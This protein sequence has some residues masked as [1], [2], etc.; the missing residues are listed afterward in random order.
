MILPGKYSKVL[1]L[2]KSFA[3]LEPPPRREL[4][5]TVELKVERLAP[6]TFRITFGMHGAGVGDGGVWLAVFTAK[7]AVQRL[8]AEGFWIH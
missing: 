4:G 7:G 8:V 2:D 1:D 6:R 5:M 3:N